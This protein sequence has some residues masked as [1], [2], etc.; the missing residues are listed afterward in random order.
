MEFTFYSKK[1]N[2]TTWL[3]DGD[4]CTSY[5]VAGDKHAIMIDNGYGE[6]DVRSYAEQLTGTKIEWTVDTHGHFDHAGGNHF[7][8]K[9]FMSKTAEKEAKTPYPSFGDKKFDFNYP[10]EYVT[11]SSVIEL[12]NHS[13]EVF[14]I[15]SHSYGDIALLDRKERILYT[16][17]NISYHAM[18]V[19]QQTE[20]QPTIEQYAVHLE[21]LMEHRDEFDYIL[22]GHGTELIPGDYVERFLEA[23]RLIMN[24]TQGEQMVIHT[25]PPQVK[26]PDGRMPKGPRPGDLK[27][28]DLEYKR[29][30]FHSGI[31]LGY[32]NRYIFNRR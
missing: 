4:G 29:E 22:S 16:G 11:D 13:L 9:I 6:V 19:Y 20:P 7:F 15:P 12:G 10:I 3:I 23:A 14:D 5:V 1:I 30:L 25:P 2:E 18:L 28:Y 8:D 17:D 31:S 26:G 24:G 27:I 21:K 32:D